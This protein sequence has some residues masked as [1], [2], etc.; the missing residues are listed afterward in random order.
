MTFS[1][2][3]VVIRDSSLG[4]NSSGRLPLGSGIR[5]NRSGVRQTFDR[6][7]ISLPQET[8]VR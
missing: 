5:C 2:V 8:P 6:I 7:Q 4:N 1:S 3:S